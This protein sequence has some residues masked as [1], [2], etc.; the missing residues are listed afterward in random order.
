MENVDNPLYRL[1]FDTILVKILSNSENFIST[2]GTKN[3]ACAKIIANPKL[4]MRDDFPD[5]F[6]PYSRTPLTTSPPPALRVIWLWVVSIFSPRIYII[7]NIYATPLIRLYN[8]MSLR[9]TTF[10]NPFHV[11]NEFIGV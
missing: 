10:N 6:I 11:S 8:W 1:S 3:P 5:E 9:P 2:A 4:F 7:W